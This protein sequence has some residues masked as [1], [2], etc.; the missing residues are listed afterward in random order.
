LDGFWSPRPYYGFQNTFKYEEEK[1]ILDKFVIVE[2]DRTRVVYNWL[3]CFTP[4]SLRQEFETAGLALDLIYADV[5][6]TEYDPD[7][8][9]F[10]VVAQKS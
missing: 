8:T 6:G 3:Q 7:A 4:E 5:S 10:A 9:E 2:E 1:V